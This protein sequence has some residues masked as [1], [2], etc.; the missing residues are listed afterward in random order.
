[1]HHVEYRIYN[2]THNFYMQI[3]A[4]ASQ[5]FCLFP[6]GMC[7]CV[8]EEIGRHLIHL[9][10]VYLL[11]IIRLYLPI[12]LSIQPLSVYLSCICLS[13][14]MYLSAYLPIYPSIIYLLWIYRASV[15]ICL[16]IIYLL[17]YLSITCLFLYPS[18]LSSIYQ[19]LSSIYLSSPVGTETQADYASCISRSQVPTISACLQRKN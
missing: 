17:T 9:S 16:S 1:M 3:Y 14:L 13:S 7:A 10:I 8:L 11:S 12:C 2:N 6:S 4:C 5:A 18:N 19:Y 15:S